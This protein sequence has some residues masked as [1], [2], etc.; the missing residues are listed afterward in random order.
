MSVWQVAVW[1]LPAIGIPALITAAVLYPAI[2]L[3]ILRSIANLFG[4]V[5]SYR[6]GCALIAAV[7]VGFAVDYW[8]HQHDDAVFAKRTA[9]F[10]QAQVERDDRI[11]KSTETLVRK[12]IA[13]DWMAQ[14]GGE[15]DVQDFES[16]LPANDAFRVGADA[17]KLR[18]IAGEAVSGP[19]KSLPRSAGKGKDAA[20]SVG[21]RLSKLGRGGVSG[22][23]NRQPSH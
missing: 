12:Q 20:H 13:D 10:E 15:K 14:Q 21:K 23:A 3:P 2:V 11:A 7:A 6:A 5:L 22:A 9:E 19:S 1:L 17:D 8:R 4:W 16:R 18:Q